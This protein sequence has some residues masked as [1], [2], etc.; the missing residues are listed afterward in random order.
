MIFIL[1]GA[2]ISAESGIRTYRTDTGLWE[3]FRIEDVASGE[4]FRRDPKL[5]QKFYDDRFV[6]MSR[7][8]PNAAHHALTRLERAFPGEVIIV[9]Q[10]IDDL[11]ERAGSV[12]VVHIHG[13]ISRTICSG[14][15]DE[16]G[17]PG[18]LAIEPPCPGCGH[19]ARPD[20]TFFG[21]VPQRMDEIEEAFLKADCFLCIGTSAEVHPAAGYIRR[22]C[23]R[24]KV[25]KTVEFNINRTSASL[26]FGR[27][28]R[29]PASISVP[30]WV[31]EYIRESCR[32]SGSPGLT[33]SFS[34]E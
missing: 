15:G 21:E 26:R 6:A 8:E 23:N 4:G 29:D 18:Y 28:C 16:L 17:S 30:A 5:V 31:D 2:G 27:L 12:N 22:A 19:L 3:E 33:T 9:T 10:N 32:K 20:I 25:K 11:H 13:S 34:H 7:A 24:K 14:C 1:T